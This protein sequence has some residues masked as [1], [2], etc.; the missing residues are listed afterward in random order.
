MRELGV[1]NTVDSVCYLFRYEFRVNDKIN[2]HSVYKA[3]GELNV[4]FR[5]QGSRAVRFRVEAFECP[6]HTP[7]LIKNNPRTVH[8]SG[9]RIQRTDVRTHV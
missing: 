9:P 6:I 3:I 8:Y 2:F 5:L 7:M 4:L 1:A